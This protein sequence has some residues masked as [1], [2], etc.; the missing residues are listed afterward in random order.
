M[1]GSD[2]KRMSLEE[3]R[4]ARGQTDWARLRSS[5]DHQGEAEFPVDWNNAVLE[6]PATKQLISLR[7]D[8]DVLEFFR[9]RGKGYQTKMNAVLRAYMLAQR[10]R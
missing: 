9:S 2:F 5:G 3:I 4:N 7:V 10:D 6:E 1:S 8:P